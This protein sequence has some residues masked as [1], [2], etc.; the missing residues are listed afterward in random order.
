[1]KTC[2]V[3]FIPQTNPDPDRFYK[4]FN[5]QIENP[6]FGNKIFLMANG[7][8]NNNDKFEGGC[9]GIALPL[10]KYLYEKFGKVNFFK[11]AEDIKEQCIMIISVNVEYNNARDNQ[12]AQKPFKTNFIY[13]FEEEE[14]LNSAEE[15]YLQKIQIK[16]EADRLFEKNRANEF[17]IILNKMKELSIACNTEEL[18]DLLLSNKELIADYS[19][20][21]HKRIDDL[22][23]MPSQAL[24]EEFSLVLIPK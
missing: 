7:I 23:K 22:I 4:I 9:S 1:M 24:L 10:S 3:I 5:G 13:I 6:P 21:I 14:I 17:W 8:F 19:K 16:K 12:L 18:V 20:L 15:V 2:D 11:P